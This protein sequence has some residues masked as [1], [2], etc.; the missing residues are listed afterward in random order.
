LANRKT[1]QANLMRIRAIKI[2]IL[3]LNIQNTV[4]FEHAQFHKQTLSRE[5]RS[6]YAIIGANILILS[7]HA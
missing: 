5:H 6:P 2:N 7:A 1:Q 3:F 4:L